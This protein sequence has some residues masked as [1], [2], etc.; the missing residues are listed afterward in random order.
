MPS[1]LRFLTFCSVPPPAPGPW[2]APYGTSD[3]P[4]A[5]LCGG[6]VLA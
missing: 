1:D 6:S 3:G 2:S 5:V 4:G